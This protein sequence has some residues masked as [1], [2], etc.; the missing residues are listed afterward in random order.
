MKKIK[1]LIIAM[2]LTAIIYAVTKN[3]VAFWILCA[4]LF[5]YGVIAGYVILKGIN[6]ERKKVMKLISDLKNETNNRIE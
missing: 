4:L 1:L 5:I 3:Q 2:Y 6:A